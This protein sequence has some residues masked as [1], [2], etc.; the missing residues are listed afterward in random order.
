MFF[1]TCTVQCRS[2]RI[3]IVLGIVTSADPYKKSFPKSVI[4]IFGFMDI[5]YISLGEKS[6][7]NHKNVNIRQKHGKSPLFK[8][9]FM[10][11][12]HSCSRKQQ[13]WVKDA[14]YPKSRTIFKSLKW[15][16]KKCGIM[17]LLYHLGG[18]CNAGERHER[19]G[20]FAGGSA[21]HRYVAFLLPPG[22]KCDKPIL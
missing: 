13:I 3:L 1:N 6:T 5:L 15:I 2:L 12:K 10:Q 22:N 21:P 17:D 8:P 20:G 14:V 9:F 7:W 16:D 18:Q 4:G 11:G 19:R